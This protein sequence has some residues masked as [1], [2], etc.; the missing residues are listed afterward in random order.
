M[1]VKYV[2]ICG[3]N[4]KDQIDFYTKKLGF[5]FVKTTNF[6]NNTACTILKGKR[7]GVGLI[8]LEKT[9]SKSTII[10]HTNDIVRDHY[11]LKTKGVSFLNEPEYIPA[12]LAAAFKDPAENYWLLLEEREYNAN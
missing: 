11:E 2:T 1:E 8:V 10:I 3:C 7:Y 4:S 9:N 12:G 5:E 6:L